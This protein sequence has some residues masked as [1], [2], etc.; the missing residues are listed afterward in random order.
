MADYLP[1]TDGDFDQW[2]S[3]F[4]DYALKHCAQLG[5]GENEI[6]ELL[7][8]CS[9]WGLALTRH[10]EAREAARLATENK[11]LQRSSGEQVIR[12]YV[13]VI[14][15]RPATTNEQRRGLGITAKPDEQSREYLLPAI[16]PHSY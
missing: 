4:V 6:A 3:N 1:R 9:R 15:A 11:E 10:R 5:L 16:H 13:R 14:Q 2:F 7:E 8:A 12:K